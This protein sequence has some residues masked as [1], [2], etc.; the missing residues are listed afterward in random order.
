MNEV[1]RAFVLMPFDSEFDAIYE[2]LIR[3]ALEDAGYEV[4]RADS[5]FDQQN[6]LRNIVRGISTAKLIVADLTT[7]NGNVMYELG[8]AHGLQIPTVLLAQSLDEVP[9]DLRSYRIVP[10]STR[11]DAVN[12]LKDR[13]GEVGRRHLAGEL[14]FGSPLTDFLAVEPQE[15]RSPAFARSEKPQEGIGAEPE[16]EKGLLDFVAEGTEA[17]ERFTALLSEINIETQQVGENIENETARLQAASGR[18]DPGSA[19]AMLRIISS[20]S[21]HMI[22]FSEAVDAK[23][24]DLEQSVEQLTEN[25]SAYIAAI[26]IEDEKDYET[27][28]E[29]RRTMDETNQVTKEGLASIRE[30]RASV[31]EMP[32]VS[33]DVNRAKRRVTGTLDRVI[34]SFERIEAFSVRAV[35]VIDEEIQSVG[36]RFKQTGLVPKPRA[37]RVDD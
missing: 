23:L 10:Y 32:G 7:V 33:R 31:D 22:R 26:H 1:A 12:A 19:K 29:L 28:S 20:A 4:T 3:P 35:G 36:S 25:Y 18:D 17:A 6:I 11:F 8:L 2:Q 14:E 30:F 34:T 27:A 16:D 15:P 9:F 21:G 37:A 24:P 5:F 13:L